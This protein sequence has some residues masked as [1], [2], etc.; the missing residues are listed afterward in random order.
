M[1]CI[2]FPNISQF[3]DLTAIVIR[4]EKVGREV[5]KHGVW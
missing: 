1:C 3:Y 4:K 5:L 2:N